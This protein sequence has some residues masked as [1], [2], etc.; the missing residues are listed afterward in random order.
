MG[1]ISG[2]YPALYLSD[3]KPVEVLKGQIVKGKS[4]EFFRKSLVTIQ[5]TVALVLIIYTFIVIRQM[6]KLKTTKLNEQGSQLLSIRFGGIAQQDRFAMFKRSVLEDPRHRTCND[7]ES[8][9][10]AGLFW[11][12]RCQC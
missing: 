11:M 9:A 6:D 2:I 7:G 4:A 1:F 3:F 10:K 8:F 5:Y 12:D